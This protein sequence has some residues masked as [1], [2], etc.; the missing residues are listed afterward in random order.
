M[1]AIEDLDRD[2]TV[3]K[4][5]IRPRN[6][7]AAGGNGSGDTRRARARGGADLER[8]EQA[9][10]SHLKDDLPVSSFRRGAAGASDLRAARRAGGAGSSRA[11]PAR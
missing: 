9:E 2:E 5:A 3:K 10:V 4:P 8:P 7:G 1:E 6:N 11:R